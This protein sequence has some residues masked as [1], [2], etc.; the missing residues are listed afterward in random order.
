VLDINW[1]TLVLGVVVLFS[2]LGGVGRGFA[3][4][5]GHVVS[6]VISAIA[7]ASALSLAWWGSNRLNLLAVRANTASEPDWLASLLQMWQQAPRLAQLLVFVL[8]F[9]V[10]SGLIRG[11][12]R[13]V[14][15]WAARAV[16]RFL[17]DSRLLGGVLGFGIGLVRSVII[18]GLL[19]IGLQYLNLPAVSAQAHA[20]KPYQWLRA[21][22]YQ[23]WLKPFM[24]RELPVLT[25][26]ALKPLAESINL[27][28]VP[29]RADASQ[30]VVV[31]PEPIVRLAK[32]V[33]A[34]DRTDREKAYDLYE[35]EIHHIHYD[36]KKY[37]DYV[38][39]QR[40][41]E[42]TPLQTLRTGKGVCADYALLYADLAHAAGLT[43]RIDEGI[44][45]TPQ[46]HGPHAWNEVWDGQ[47][48]RWIP[49]DTT[50][51]SEQ[52][53]WFDAPHFGWTHLLQH[54]IEIKGSG[55]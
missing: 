55:R 11:W 7:G 16:P 10:V 4:E 17:A 27:V 44:G 21:T 43:V 40:W 35:W 48:G 12:F 3:Y 9:S 29:T 52:D 46:Q 39:H 6:L 23:P 20:S 13:T 49:L 30:G 19:F 8:I 15:Y 41:D 1:V 5:S 31:V 2:V 38:Y 28:A 47:Q 14:P 33:T 32:Q 37:D 34:G 22:V 24:V 36:W 25:E 18:G 50:W 53:V 51:G 45:G 26:G 42:Q 54:T